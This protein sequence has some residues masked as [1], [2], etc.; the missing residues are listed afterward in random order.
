M[1]SAVIGFSS[2]SQFLDL[3]GGQD[4]FGAREFFAHFHIPFVK[5]A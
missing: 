4:A 1:S 5:A 2:T 3:F